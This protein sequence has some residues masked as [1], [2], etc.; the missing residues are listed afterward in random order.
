VRFFADALMSFKNQ[1]SVGIISGSNFWGE[2]GTQTSLPFADYPLTW[3]W[4][5]WR[6][7]WNILKKPFFQD[8]KID[9]GSL[10]M[11]E[12][13]FW[14]TGVE[15]CM[16]RKLDAWDIPFAANFKSLNF[17]A[18]IPHQNFVTNV[19]FDEHAGNTFEDVWPLNTKIKE[20][21]YN[22]ERLEVSFSDDITQRI[23][24]DIYKI[25]F[26]SVLTRPVRLIQNF[27]KF[28]KLNA[29]RDAI[30]NVIIPNS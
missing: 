28:G 26:R 4:A 24:Q 27:R 1:K 30:G 2:I 6:D 19:G 13:L 11:R 12:R 25:N 14:R 21:N 16:N 22:S 3:G 29:L 17:K 8:S 9:L 10:S 5:T 18:V 23:V 20:K 15:R 7:R